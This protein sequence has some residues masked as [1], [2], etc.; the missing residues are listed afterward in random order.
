MRHLPVIIAVLVVVSVQSV[1]RDKQ[2]YEEI[3]KDI[4]TYTCRP[5]P[6][7]QRQRVKYMYMYMYALSI[8]RCRLRVKWIHS[9]RLAAGT[10]DEALRP[11]RILRQSDSQPESP[12]MNIVYR[13]MNSGSSPAPTSISAATV[14]RAKKKRVIRLYCLS[15]RGWGQLVQCGQ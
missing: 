6:L 14:V 11:A 13:P 5:L 9:V 2:V 8:C 15:G 7:L 12:Y 4:H 1:C 3:E 10:G